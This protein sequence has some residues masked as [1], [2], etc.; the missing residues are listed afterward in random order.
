[1]LEEIIA[2]VG[3]IVLHAPTWAQALV[4]GPWT[5]PPARRTPCCQMSCRSLPAALA[6]TLTSSHQL[7][8]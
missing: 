4:A 7:H 1:M 8:S 3:V 6:E 2:K 5:A